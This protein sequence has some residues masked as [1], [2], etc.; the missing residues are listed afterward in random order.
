[1]NVGDYHLTAGSPAID[2]ANSDAPNET[3][4]DIEGNARVDDP[5]TADSG[6]GTRTYDDRG[7][8]EFQPVPARFSLFADKQSILN[9]LTT[10]RA[11]VSNKKD[12]K[13]LDKAIKNL[14]QSLS[15][16]L[17]VDGSHLDQRRGQGIQGRAGCGQGVA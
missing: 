11:Q 3:T 8:Y 5:S 12:G 17:W 7:A 16:D 6:V 4:L 14:T 13:T 1:M 9:D 15:P 2:S 10:L